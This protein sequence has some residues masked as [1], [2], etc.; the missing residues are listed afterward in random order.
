MYFNTSNERILEAWKSFNDV[1]KA[2]QM[3]A[4][5]ERA[6]RKAMAHFE[7]AYKIMQALPEQYQVALDDITKDLDKDSK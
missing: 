4:E 3:A 7:A 2:E 1:V 5:Y 6:Q